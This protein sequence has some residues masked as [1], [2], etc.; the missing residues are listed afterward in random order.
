MENHDYIPTSLNYEDVAPANFAELLPVVRFLYNKL[1]AVVVQEAQDDQQEVFQIQLRFLNLTQNQLNQSFQHFQVIPELRCSNTTPDLYK[2]ICRT[3]NPA[4]LVTRNL[5]DQVSA[6][7]NDNDLNQR[8]KIRAAEIRAEDRAQ[9]LQNMSSYDAFEECFR[10]FSGLLKA[11][12]QKAMLGVQLY[13]GIHQW[14]SDVTILRTRV[15]EMLMS[16]GDRSEA[17]NLALDI[18]V[19]RRASQTHYD[20]F[21]NK[22]YGENPQARY[23]AHFS[24]HGPEMEVSP[25]S[26]QNLVE[27]IRDGNL[28]TATY[29]R[30]PNQR[31][32][33]LDDPYIKPF[34]TEL[35]NLIDKIQ[36]YSPGPEAQLDVRRRR[37]LKRIVELKGGF[38]SFKSSST[39][40][41]SRA[42]VL[43]DTLRFVSKNCEEVN[44]EGIDFTEDCLGIE[45][46]QITDM[47][48]YVQGY[49]DKEEELR[50]KEDL[51]MKLS[52][53]EYT[54]NLPASKLPKLRS[55]A[56]FLSWSQVTKSMFSVI[57]NDLSRVCL[58]KA[59]L[60]N[61]VDINFL[62]SCYNSTEML[63]YLKKK[64]SDRTY[65]VAMELQKLFD[66]RNC[67]DNIGT[68]I[69]NA[70][71]LLLTYSY[72]KSH[73]LLGKFDRSVRDRLFDKLFTN[74]QKT[75]FAIEAVR[76]E[77][78]WRLY[79]E[80]RLPPPTASL[81]NLAEGE[82]EVPHYSTPVSTPN[83]STVADN[84]DAGED[85]QKDSASVILAPKVTGDLEISEENE[86]KME[87][88]R[89][90]LFFKLHSRFYEAARRIHFSAMVLDNKSSKIKNFH[91]QQNQD[92]Q[93][94]K[95][96][97]Y[98]VQHG[99]TCPLCRN[100]HV[101][102]LSKCKVFTNMSSAE[103]RHRALSRMKVNVC[104]RC[105][106]F[107]YDPLDH[108]IIDNKC[109]LQTKLNISCKHPLC[110]DNPFSHSPLLC[111]RD[112]VEE[113]GAQAARGNH[114]G[115][116]GRGQSQGRGAGRGP[117]RGAG[118]ARGRGAGQRGRSRGR[119]QFRRQSRKSR[120]SG[121]EKSYRVTGA[122]ELSDENRDCFD[123]S[124]RLHPV[125]FIQGVSYK[126]HKKEKL[127]MNE[128][129]ISCAS[130]C[131]LVGAKRDLN[132]TCLFDSGSSLSFIRESTAKQL[133][134][135][136]DSQ[137]NG[138]LST[139]TR[140]SDQI[141]NIY[142]VKVRGEDDTVYKVP[143]LGV[144]DIGFRE[145]VP[146]DALDALCKAAGIC[147][148]SLDQSSG[149]L[150]LLLG[151]NCYRLFPRSVKPPGH[152][153]LSRKHPNIKLFYSVLSQAMFFSGQCGSQYLHSLRDEK[154]A[155]N[156]MINARGILQS[157]FRRLSDKSRRI[158]NVDSDD[159]GSAETLRPDV[160]CE[161]RA[162]ALDSIS[163]ECQASSINLEVEDYYQA[164]RRE[165]E[166]VATNQIK[167][168]GNLYT[169]VGLSVSDSSCELKLKCVSSHCSIHQKIQNFRDEVSLPRPLPPGS[170][171]PVGYVNMIRGNL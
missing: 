4:F 7:L 140:K 166:S 18:L 21:L 171:Y 162:G 141:F 17:N 68:M 98:Q 38:E 2:L 165:E 135:R 28:I 53:S 109:S 154:K 44:L 150:S 20:S 155:N 152:D 12:L 47:I 1:V 40:K 26:Y 86:D 74:Q 39:K 129:D 90:K 56:D 91:S 60:G 145:Q 6:A 111:R 123:D 42:R 5:R 139:L 151:T 35:D 43:L 148:E 9:P 143:C 69:S 76:S 130:S 142:I 97:S 82:S 78:Y 72:F 24:Y 30:T 71:V 95:Y 134:L 73:N 160:T 96:Y 66:L 127:D 52:S 49:I 119:G 113:D 107:S 23:N 110:V 167:F 100:G 156:Y 144:E 131:T 34:S 161:D 85:D 157:S 32:N 84:K 79:D 121:S 126:I 120:I 54:K 159:S 64:Y 13:A 147:K 164:P 80:G 48:E 81:I 16:L 117:G 158:E 116:R 65:I 45:P 36:A 168:R 33:I 99:S 83:T 103:E 124:C 3:L 93:N 125:N 94:K 14:T 149:P 102:N 67:G 163:M 75:M 22:T 92:R 89:R 88:R 146:S 136:S 169:I 31:L 15:T 133:R 70:E 37:L 104:R 41:L 170:R 106:L 62:A 8:L 153:K 59:S 108:P 10:D 57:K 105:L 132:G 112:P 138:F 122:E 51:N 58:I 46:D 11:L 77:G 61:Q 137:W 128:L 63:E 25:F 114:R 115:Q 27:T 87:I 55:P 101:N 50:K 29:M 118:Q 19:R